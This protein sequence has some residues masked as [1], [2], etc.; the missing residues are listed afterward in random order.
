MAPP[1]PQM[2]PK[3]SGLAELVFLFSFFN[4]SKKINPPI[5][6]VWMRVLASTDGSLLWLARTN[7]TAADNLKR[8]AE[9]H[10][11][12][13]ARLIFAPRV[14]NTHDHLAR[15]ACADLF[16]D[17]LPYNA[18][19]TAADA[20]AAGVPVLTCYGN[21]FAG[22]VAASLMRQAGLPEFVTSSLEEY[23]SRAVAFA[24]ETD[25]LAT[26]KATLRAS[27]SFDVHEYTRRLEAAY[28]NMWRR[29]EQGLAPQSFT[30]G[31]GQ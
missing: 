3:G 29:A 13:P 9:R 8:E 4:T 7:A 27:R 15:L 28:E 14:P 10:R 19:T 24:N 23:E 22:R 1:L 30:A 31:G 25:T 16:L 6:S 20:L 21:S 2:P 12:S 11:V 18:H 5:F 26:A 17:T